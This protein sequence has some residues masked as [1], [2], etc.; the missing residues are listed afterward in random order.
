MLKLLKMLK[1]MLLLLAA[2]LLVQVIPAA[3]AKERV[4]SLAPHLTEMMYALGA[5]DQLVGVMRF[6]DYPEAAKKLPVIGDAY[7]LN[8]EQ[9]VAAKP[10][11]VLAWKGGTPEKQIEKL[12]SLKLS[13]EVINTDTLK[14][15]PLSMSNIARKLNNPNASISINGQFERQFKTLQTQYSRLGTTE[16]VKVFYEIWSQPLMTIGNKHP[17]NEAIT[18]CGGVNVF[19]DIAQPTPTVSREALLTRKPQVLLNA[20]GD[21]VKPKKTSGETLFPKLPHST[22]NGDLISRMGPRFLQGVKQMCEVIDVVRVT[23]Q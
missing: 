10:T 21:D 7:A 23:R 12:R 18:L 1:R 20:A 13:V 3:Q 2:A 14:D 16:P 5:G 15:I 8:Y 19:K 11:L 6:S 4:I 9:I 17:I 22:I